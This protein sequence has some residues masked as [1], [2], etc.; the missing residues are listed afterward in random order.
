MRALLQRTR[1]AH[2]VGQ[3]CR[4]VTGSLAAIHSTRLGRALR[5]PTTLRTATRRTAG[6]RRTSTD[7]TPKKEKPPSFHSEKGGVVENMKTSATRNAETLP[8]LNDLVGLA[9][10]GLITVQWLMDDVLV[11]RSFGLASCASMVIFNLC[12]K[13][14][15]ML[16]VYF[17]V[18]FIAVNG[19]FIARIVDER[20]DVELCGDAALLWESALSDSGLPRKAV[21]ALV[22]AGDVVL[23]Q[24]GEIRCREGAPRRNR[25]AV[26][27]QGELSVDAKGEHLAEIPVGDVVG[28]FGFMKKRGAEGPFEH[29]STSCGGGA[30]CRLISWE[31]DALDDHVASRPATRR[32]VEELF[33][34]ARRP[35]PST[36]Q[37]LDGV[38]GNSRVAANAGEEAHR[39]ARAHERPSRPRPASVARSSDQLAAI[40]PR[41]MSVHK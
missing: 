23:L 5:T 33:A 29:V 4:N 35:N 15:V 30:A 25:A 17:N 11:L 34:R 3:R 32:A 19:Y 1:R 18:L 12:R 37:V 26:V 28:E 14:P 9:G 31:Y 39:E 36:R 2:T 20:R 10:F 21:Q 6:L 40:A 16:P 27:L 24:P 38:E 22:E 41:M 13:P 8:A 7:A